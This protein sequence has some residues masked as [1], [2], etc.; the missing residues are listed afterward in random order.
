MNKRYLG[1]PLTAL[2]TALSAFILVSCGDDESD[3]QQ[4]KQEVLST[5]DL[6]GIW[7]TPNGGYSDLWVFN[8]D[9]TG[10]L[11]EHYNNA[12]TGAE[13]TLFNYTVGETER[14]VSIQPTDSETDM[15]STTLTVS[16]KA[17]GNLIATEGSRHFDLTRLQT[18]PEIADKPAPPSFIIEEVSPV[19]C[20]AEYFYLFMYNYVDDEICEYT[21]DAD[22]LTIGGT[23]TSRQFDTRF[24]ASAKVYVQNNYGE[25][26]RFADIT[27]TMKST[28][29]KKTVTVMQKPHLTLDNDGVDDYDLP[30]WGSDGDVAF[31]VRINNWD[32]QSVEL[33]RTA[34]WVSLV[35]TK[36]LKSIGDGGHQILY[37]FS[38]Q[39]N[40]GY[41]R[42]MNLIFYKASRESVNVL[43]YE[44]GKRGP[45]G[46]ISGDGDCTHCNGSGI[47]PV[48]VGRGRNIY[49]Y[50]GLVI[51]CSNCHGTG[52][53][54]WCD[55]TGWQAEGSG[56]GTSTTSSV[57]TTSDRCRWCGGKRDCRNVISGE[58]DK[59]F[60]HGTGKCQWCNG[61]GWY[62][63]MG[64]KKMMCPN[65]KKPG[66][67]SKGKLG[68]GKCNKCNG[69]G[70]CS[71]CI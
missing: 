21:T 65:C 15:Q 9:Q 41:D 56:T 11:Y 18:M 4:P 59:Y 12:S 39:R 55:G 26:E 48:C 64:Y 32:D 5:A 58:A 49:S 30:Y 31:S 40:T 61:K 44:K 19:H 10:T 51:D 47:C 25:E 16:R 3:N 69:T 35:S 60:C 46:G 52:K 68:D 1:L 33:A 57:T 17:D 23:E 53:C 24:Y 62:Y 20:Y 14:T 45:Q 38:Y 13:L 34:S 71:H 22:W 66:D 36:N 70:K 50:G 43:V 63:G 6:L 27:G 67:N 28:G 37:N 8:D 7:T 2:M 42:T 29:E 54:W